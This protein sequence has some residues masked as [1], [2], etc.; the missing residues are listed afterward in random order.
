M[1]AVILS[2]EGFV[3]SLDKNV[4]E[5]LASKASGHVKAFRSVGKAFAVGSKV[6]QICLKNKHN[7]IIGDA[8]TDGIS[9]AC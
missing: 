6:T 7:S 4:F 1:V 8:F 5:Q 3:P 2:L 9:I